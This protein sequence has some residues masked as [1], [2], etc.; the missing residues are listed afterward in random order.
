[1]T[2]D[3]MAEIRASFFIHER[4]GTIG[5]LRR[6]V[7]PLGYLIDVVEW[8]QTVPPPCPRPFAISGWS[9]GGAPSVARS[10]TV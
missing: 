1:M 10:W 2:N 4:N 9:N 8:W 3:P 5:A 6:A 7:E